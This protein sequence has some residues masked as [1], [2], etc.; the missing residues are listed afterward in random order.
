M[1]EGK[2]LHFQQSIIAGSSVL[3]FNK[4]HQEEAKTANSNRGR[5]LTYRR[6]IDENGVPNMNATRTSNRNNE[7]PARGCTEPLQETTVPQESFSS[8][9]AGSEPAARTLERSND[10]LVEEQHFIR[11]KC[12][13][14]IEGNKLTSS[15][16]D[17]LF[18]AAKK[19]GAEAQNEG[20]VDKALNY[21]RQ[22]LK[23]KK[24][25]VFQSPLALQ[26][27]YAEMLYEI[28]IIQMESDPAKSHEAF[29]LCLDMRRC[30]FGSTNRLVAEVLFKLAMLY[31]G[32]GDHQYALSLL[33]ETHCIVAGAAENKDKGVLAA[34]WAA[35]SQ[36]Q[37]SLGQMEEAW[38]S[39]QAA[40]EL[41]RGWEFLQQ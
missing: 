12:P 28:G 37:K 32:I 1:F 20:Q 17:T 21:Y 18:F 25:T 27:A 26:E 6:M 11:K 30:L 38:S 8:I 35:I 31:T 14:I 24:R 3:R 40:E 13:E 16:E 10:N 33:L 2:A 23:L 19:S 15:I 7:P 4:T 9:R 39:F 22:A 34:V 36:T 41:R 29:R 5:E